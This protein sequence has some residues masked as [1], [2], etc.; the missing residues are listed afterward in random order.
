MKMMADVQLF[1]AHSHS[2]LPQETDRLM[3][4]LHVTKLSIERWYQSWKR[5]GV[6]EFRL[7]VYKYFAGASLSFFFHSCSAQVGFG[8]SL[9]Q[10][11]QAPGPRQ[12]WWV[13][14]LV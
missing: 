13:V 2:M 10:A 14:V 12:Y 3:Y 7:N 11:E 4:Q 6:L 8:S 5:I 9:S 1:V